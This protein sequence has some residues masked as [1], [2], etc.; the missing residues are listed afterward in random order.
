MVAD[1]YSGRGW[2]Q[3]RIGDVAQG[4]EQSVPEVPFMREP[5]RAG[6]RWAAAKLIRMACSGC[7]LNSRFLAR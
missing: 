7:G 6:L 3:V 2:W 4:G 5:I 1:D